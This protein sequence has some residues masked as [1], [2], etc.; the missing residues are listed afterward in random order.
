MGNKPQ[1]GQNPDKVF[2]ANFSKVMAGLGVIF[3]IC[4]VAAGIFASGDIRD[5]EGLKAQMQERLAPIGTVITDPEVLLQASA[6]AAV[7]REPYT[8]TEVVERVCAACH[9]TGVL[10]APKI[11]DNAVWS[12]RLS[13]KGLETLVKH[14]IEGFNS[15]PARGGDTSLSDEEVHEAVEHLLE[16]SDVSI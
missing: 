16:A 13:E 3:V 11:G 9:S 6:A 2:M 5:D 8:G 15:M 7:S 10:D 14:S 12:Q 1:D 4:L